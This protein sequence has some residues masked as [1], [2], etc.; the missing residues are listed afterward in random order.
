MVMGSVGDLR[1][2]IPGLAA[3][4]GA[5]LARHLDSNERPLQR[6]SGTRPVDLRIARSGGEAFFGA[7]L[8]L[9]RARDVDFLGTLG[10]FRKHSNTVSE[11]FSKAADDGKMPIT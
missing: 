9:F 7:L 2:L 4:S 10:S 11:N 1:W 5:A 8:G 3:D 6:N